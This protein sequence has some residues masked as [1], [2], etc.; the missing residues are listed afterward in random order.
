MN[1]KQHFTHAAGSQQEHL[2]NICLFETERQQFEEWGVSDVGRK[3]QPK[4]AQPTQ[5]FQSETGNIG[6]L[7]P[8]DCLQTNYNFVG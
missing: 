8:A 6:I 7:L 3:S 1:Y 5:E 4:I 2:I